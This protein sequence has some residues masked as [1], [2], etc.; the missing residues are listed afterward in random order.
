MA[1]TTVH[2]VAL[3]DLI[4]PLSDTQVQSLM[5]ASIKGDLNLDTIAHHFVPHL[6]KS[7]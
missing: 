3:I 7:L 6:W 1:S 2:N 4:L 5:D